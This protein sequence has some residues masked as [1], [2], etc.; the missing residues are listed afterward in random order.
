MWKERE[1][2]P[3]GFIFAIATVSLLATKV[4]QLLEYILQCK[5]LLQHNFADSFQNITVRNF[6]ARPQIFI[7]ASHIG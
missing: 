7:C 6:L 5:Q 2:F 1:H 3:R 4:H